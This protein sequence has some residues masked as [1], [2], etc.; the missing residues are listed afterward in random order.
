MLILIFAIVV[1]K[2]LRDLL[3][4]PCIDVEQMLFY[5]KV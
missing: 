2:I 1:K 4:I 3:E 5:M